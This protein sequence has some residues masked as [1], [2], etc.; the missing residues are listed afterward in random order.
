LGL[1]IALALLFNR[2]MALRKGGVEERR[3]TYR[4]DGTASMAVITYRLQDGSTTRPEDVSLP[5]QTTMDFPESEM[6]ILTASNPVQTGILRCQIL[7]DGR[8]W[9]EEKAASETDKVSC[10]GILP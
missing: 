10:G 9:I 2:M 1:L 8:H 4:V 5:W 3:V 6:V 7:L